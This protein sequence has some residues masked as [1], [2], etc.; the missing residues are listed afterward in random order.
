MTTLFCCYVLVIIFYFYF[1]LITYY[2]Y[3]CYSNTKALHALLRTH[4]HN[5][6]GVD[7]SGPWMRI[8]V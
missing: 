3:L 1:G 7:V 2:T 6:F 8:D 4:T 5:R